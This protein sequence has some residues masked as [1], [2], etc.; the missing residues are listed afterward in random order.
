MYEK[1]VVPT[2]G[3]PVSR[4]VLP[5]AEL[6]AG[7]FGSS[8]EL[9]YCLDTDEIPEDVSAKVESELLQ[10]LEHVA[11]DL[12]KSLKP[13][14]VV[15]PG[16]PADTIVDRA[17]EAPGNLIAMCTHGYYGLNRWILGS[18]TSKVVQAANNPMLVVRAKPDGKPVEPLRIDTILVALDGSEL[19]E[20]TLAH[21]KALAPKLGAAVVLVR[22]YETRLPG[23]SIR[24][25]K[26]DEL[27]HDAATAYLERKA[28]ELRQQG[29]NDVST[30]ALHG[31]PA[32]ELID[33][34]AKV[35]NSLLAM[36]SHG[37]SGVG[38]W[39]L[40]SVTTAVIRHSE[41]PMLVVR[42]D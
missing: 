14:C 10:E 41:H 12:P 20:K 28:E 39:M 13:E 3:S 29:L 5:L 32:G 4:Q 7:C 21:V 31:R 34:A 37:R 17:A 33:Y 2:D 19:A 42:A 11:A 1:I 6:V 16:R 38:R 9:L 24:M 8:L 15:V 22:A 26:V 30:H 25:Y 18:V 23:S 40:G 36:S 27:V 35:P